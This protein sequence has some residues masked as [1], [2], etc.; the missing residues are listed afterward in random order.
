MYLLL[1]E[2]C[3]KNVQ[4]Q[5]M[6]E[7]VFFLLYQ[8]SSIITKFVK[9]MKSS[10]S[11]AEAEESGIWSILF[12]E[13]LKLGKGRKVKIRRYKGFQGE[14]K[15]WVVWEGQET[16]SI[17]SEKC[18]CPLFIIPLSM[19]LERERERERERGQRHYG[20]YSKRSKLGILSF[21]ICASYPSIPCILSRLSRYPR[22]PHSP[23]YARFPLLFLSDS[24]MPPMPPINGATWWH[25]RSLFI[26]FY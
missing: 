8:P 24:P 12:I 16:K 6:M 23:R 13:K 25:G 7:K 19:G 15:N 5:F 20:H 9:C 10:D 18:R 14:L 22:Y 1:S 17:R 4:Y 21:F 26:H 2:Y 3:L 11:S